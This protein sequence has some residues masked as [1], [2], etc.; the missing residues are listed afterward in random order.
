MTSVSRVIVALLATASLLAACAEPG[1]TVAP[2]PTTPSTPTL[3]AFP[4]S[5]SDG[6][7][8]SARRSP[9]PAAP[10][11]V[12]PPPTAAPWDP[13]SL[14]LARV[15]SGLQR[16][17]WVGSAGDGSGRLFVLEQAGTIR[18]TRDGRLVSRPYLNIRDRVSAGGERGLLALAFA[19]T[20]ARDGR[21]YVDARGEIW[22]YGLRNP[23]R[24]SFDRATGDLWIG[25]VG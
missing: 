23:W 21:F 5:P 24:F 8:T 19:P 4:A 25:D 18:V 12:G 17:L 11:P 7:N 15:V 2:V 20:F 1:P 9:S 16:P 6:P 3:T 14:A 22:A 13:L 10:S